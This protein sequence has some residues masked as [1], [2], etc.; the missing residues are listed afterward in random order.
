[1]EFV[2]IYDAKTNLSKYLDKVNK[3]HEPIVICR[4]GNP[5]GLLTEFK[6]G[7]LKVLGKLK[8]KIKISKDFDAELPEDI[9]KDYE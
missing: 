5:I 9:M 2:N 1:M 4:N 7:K 6:S 8:G 3:S